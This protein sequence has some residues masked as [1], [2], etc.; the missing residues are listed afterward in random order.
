L[1]FELP[2]A[3]DWVHVGSGFGLGVLAVLLT[4]LAATRRV[5]QAPPAITLRALQN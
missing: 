4:G 2:F 3:P 5:V 1:V